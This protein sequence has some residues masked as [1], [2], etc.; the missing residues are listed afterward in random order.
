M[1]G[2]T[3]GLKALS[4][5]SGIFSSVAACEGDRGLRDSERM[6]F[7][8]A[9]LATVVVRSIGET[10]YN[11]LPLL[12]RR[13]TVD[14]REFAVSIEK[15]GTTAPRTLEAPPIRSVL[16]IRSTTVD[17][18]GGRVFLRFATFTKIH[19]SPCTRRDGTQP[20]SHSQIE[21][22]HGDPRFQR[23]R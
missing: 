21:H 18:S 13:V 14:S 3:Y 8:A 23:S 5:P 22:T 9:R 17:G 7:C 19:A 11:M 15:A 6:G 12:S 4:Q 2:T 16:C 20:D 10:W 1:R